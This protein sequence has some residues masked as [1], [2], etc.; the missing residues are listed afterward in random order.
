MSEHE[1]LQELI[2]IYAL[3]ALTRS[4][5][6]RVQAH[7]EGCSVCLD[8]LGIHLSTAAALDGRREPP[9]GVWEVIVEQVGEPR[10]PQLVDLSA[11]RAGRVAR[12]LLAAAAAVALVFSGAVI[13]QLVDDDAIGAPELLA[14]A[15]EAT[16]RPGSVVTDFM[17]D[18]I[19]VARLVLTSEGQGFIVPTDELPTLDES[20]TYQL[21]VINAQEA[22]ISAGVLGNLPGPSVFTWSGEIV[23]LALTREVA[24]GVVSSEGDVVSV[25]T[26]L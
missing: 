12:Y 10:I 9:A 14:A 8:E 20:R 16:N 23:G 4:E 11:R 3:G 15:E 25:V 24:G 21:W 5:A 1:Q 22:V 17:V 13:A 7:I 6:A 19:S 18:E 2:P 26:D